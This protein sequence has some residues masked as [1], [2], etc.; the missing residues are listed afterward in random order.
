MAVMELDVQR[1][2]TLM[3][4]NTGSQDL[5]A[6]VVSPDGSAVAGVTRE[7]P[8]LP[9]AVVGANVVGSGARDAVTVAW[10]AGALLLWDEPLAAGALVMDPVTVSAGP[11]ALAVADLDGNGSGDAAVV[12]DN[13]TLMVVWDLGLPSQHSQ[14]VLQEPG[15]LSSVAVG[16]V[17]GD[18]LPDVVVTSADFDSVLVV[19]GVAGGLGAPV[20]YPSLYAPG[21]LT[22]ADVDGDGRLD[23]VVV[24]AASG[25]VALYPSSPAGLG[26]AQV[27]VDTGEPTA[28]ALADMDGDGAMDAVVAGAD[29]FV[30][31]RAPAMAAV[32]TVRV[33][34]GSAPVAVVVEDVNLDGAP[35]VA[36]LNQVGGDVV[37][38]LNQSF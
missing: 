36:V 35:D 11:R 9:V 22:L 25:V 30:S 5:R 8:G 27:M 14:V 7:L 12:H 33:W 2:L 26:A 1:G 21:A 17:T 16:D 23:V 10:S 4:A 13:G 15:R 18:G 19:P 37:V 29:G 3:T 6:V 32:R 24:H 34:A 20:R 38:L 31:V 28:V